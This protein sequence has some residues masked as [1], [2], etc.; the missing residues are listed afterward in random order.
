MLLFP[1]NNLYIDRG[2]D[3]D[4]YYKHTHKHIYTYTYVHTHTHICYCCHDLNEKFIK[5]K[6]ASV[7]DNVDKRLGFKKIKLDKILKKD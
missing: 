3:K 2:I 6:V 5:V 1:L 4:L 7:V